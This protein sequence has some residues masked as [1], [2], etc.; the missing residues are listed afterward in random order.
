M[1]W[2]VLVFAA[3]AEAGP[4]PEVTF[5]FEGQPECVQ[6]AYADGHTQLTNGCDHAILLDQSVVLDGAPLV[7]AGATKQIRDLSGFSL[8]MDGHLYR[9]VAT[10]QADCPPE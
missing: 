3:L 4:C 10:L 8:G 1:P 2:F 9:V 7:G 5:T 6:L